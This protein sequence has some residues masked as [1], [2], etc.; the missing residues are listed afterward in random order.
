MGGENY[1]VAMQSSLPLGGSGSINRHATT[2]AYDGRTL[3]IDILDVINDLEGFHALLLHVFLDAVA[4]PES[5]GFPR[6]WHCL[7]VRKL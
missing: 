6:L 3:A 2:E 7:R 4:K 5:I 1:L